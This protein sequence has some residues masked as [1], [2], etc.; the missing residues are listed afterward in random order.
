[1]L[2]NSV[3]TFFNIQ[4]RYLAIP[5]AKINPEVLYTGVSTM[6]ILLPSTEFAKVIANATN[7]KKS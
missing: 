5:A 1:M 2:R 4:K 3:R 6:V 7:F